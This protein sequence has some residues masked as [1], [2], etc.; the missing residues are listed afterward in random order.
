MNGSLVPADEARVSVFDRGVLFGEGVYES[1]RI[2][3]GRAPFLPRHQARLGRSLAAIGLDPD[4]AAPLPPA[5]DAFA[6]TDRLAEGNL[7]LQVTRGGTVGARRHVPDAKS[8]PTIF[9]FATEAP[10]LDEEPASIRAVVRPDELVRAP[11]ADP[12]LAEAFHRLTPGR[13]RSHVLHID[14]AKTSQTRL[15]R[16]EALRP[17]ILAGKSALDR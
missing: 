16:L 7:S 10:P 5:V 17:L 14:G 8:A 13:Q 15:R 4:L 3:R 11:D 9:A 12:A 6:G 2:C 1:V